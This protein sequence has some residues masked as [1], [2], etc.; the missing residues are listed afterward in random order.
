MLGKT[1]TEE[2]LTKSS[3]KNLKWLECKSFSFSRLHSREIFLQ[4][5][6]RILTSER[7]KRS[8]T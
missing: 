2:L 1:S 4:N 6:E 5:V 8:V 7:E 3:W